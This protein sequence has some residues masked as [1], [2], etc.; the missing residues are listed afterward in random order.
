[1]SKLWHGFNFGCWVSQSTLKPPHIDTFY[2]EKD[3][4]LVMD[5]GFN[6]V[7]LPVDYMFF[8]SDAASG[9]YDESRLKYVDRCISWCKKYGVHVNLDLHHAPG[10][11]EPEASVLAPWVRCL[12]SS[13]C[14]SYLRTRCRGAFRGRGS[15]LGVWASIP[16]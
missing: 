11:R 10:Y 3:V 16:L 4:S 1:M 5:W 8:E 7:R 9:V 12:D 15:R 14:L 13:P 6:F 2:T